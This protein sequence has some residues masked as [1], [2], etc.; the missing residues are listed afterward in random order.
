MKTNLR[1]DFQRGDWFAIALAAILALFSAVAFVFPAPS[2]RNAQLQILQDGRL[3]REL[4]LQGSMDLQMTGQYINQI[5]IRDG[6]AAIIASNCP[7][8]DCVH[9]GWIARPGRA[10]VCLPNHVELRV[11]GDAADLDLSLG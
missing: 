8:Q 11:R 3:I 4:P 10:I 1:L 2:A 7:G 6:R 9:S 5:A